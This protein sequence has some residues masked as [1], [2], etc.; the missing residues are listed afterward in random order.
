[1]D[2]QNQNQTHKRRVRYKG[3]HPRS[4]HE[5]YKE[6]NPEKYADTIE[7][8]IR[9]GST[10]A[11]MHISICVNEILDFLQIKPGQK[12]LDATL[13]YGGHT[14]AMLNCLE[15]NGHIYGLDIDPIEI[16]KTTARLRQQGYG[17]EVLTVI[18]TNFANLSEVARQHGP[19]D[20]ILADLGVSSM[21]IDN[22]ERGFSYK[23]D[24]PLDLRLNPQEGVS[25]AERL[26]ELSE[27]EFA[28]MM[29]ENSDEPYAH[30]IAQTVMR[31][32]RS[33]KKVD[34]TT[35]L[36][37]L[38]EKALIKLPEKERKEAVKKSCQR[39]FQALRI[40]VNSE[41]EVLYAFLDALPD[42]LAPGGRAAILTFHSG[43]DRLVKKSFKQLKKQGIYTEVCEDVIRPSVQEC[44]MNPRAKSTKMRWAVR[45]D[46]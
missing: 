44:A 2:N 43:E 9:K 40:D 33:G 10:P 36:R 23:I 28:W 25:A 13:G 38:I 22:P 32:L 20:F 5:K 12:G 7:K 1:M 31:E 35:R 21:Q 4:F 14:K 15:G 34:T 41:F 37:E 46:V 18:N 19:F 17:E 29:I 11:G 3:T 42:A 39:T 24:G 27:E 16:E 30:E 6:H 45:S 26:T 8:V